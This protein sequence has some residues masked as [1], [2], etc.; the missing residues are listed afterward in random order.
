MGVPNY[1]E[2]LEKIQL[3]STLLEFVLDVRCV[4]SF[5]NWSPSN[6]EIRPHFQFHIFEPPLYKL[7]EEWAK[8]LKQNEDQSSS[9]K[10]EVLSLR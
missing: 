2:C 7:W 9:L 1:T 5:R 6:Y 3:S 10:V 4:A 8:C